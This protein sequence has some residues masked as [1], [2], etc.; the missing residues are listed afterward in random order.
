[1][2]ETH[3]RSFDSLKLW[4]YHILGILTSFYYEDSTINT[5]IFLIKEAFNST[6]SIAIENDPPLIE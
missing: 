1:M 6:D 2:D 4:T 5:L 3:K